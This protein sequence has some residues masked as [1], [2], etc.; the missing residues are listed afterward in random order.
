MT[1][2][3]ASDAAQKD[4]DGSKQPRRI[5]AGDLQRVVEAMPRELRDDDGGRTFA[6]AADVVRHFVGIEWFAANVRHDAP[7]PG[8]LRL[9]FTSDQT[10]AA[11]VFRLIDLAECLYNLQHIPGF[12]E[13]IDQM[14]AG[15]EKIE[16]TCAELDFA[17]LLY[18]HDVTFRFVVPAQKIKGDD[19][20]FEILFRD[21]LAVAA[22]AK[23]K[24]ESTAIDVRSIE[25]S[26]RKARRQ[27][28][29]DR[30][31]IIFVKTPQS[32]IADIQTANALVQVGSEFLRRTSRVVSVKFYV[33]HLDRV[34]DTLR[35]RH[36]F[37]ELTNEHSKFHAGRDW[38]LFDDRPVP[39][40]WNGMPPK[41]QRIFFFPAKGEWSG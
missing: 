5:T 28:P 8:F 13:C 4:V 38:D 16:S 21:G 1:Q 30:P 3:R 34:G 11:T 24:F 22:D 9:D 40:E 27:L 26:L 15:A 19:Y 14:R 20:D 17:R 2:I 23:C 37:R 10:R 32:W 12:D 18:I 36:A 25:N 39:A 35:H 31:G 33:W 41:W 7:R 6:L 29:A